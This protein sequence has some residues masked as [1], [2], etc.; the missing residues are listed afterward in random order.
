MQIRSIHKAILFFLV[1][2]IC[3]AHAAIVSRITNFT[4]GT[5]LYASDLNSEFNNIINTVNNLDNDNLSTTANISSSKISATIAGDG[6]GRDGG[7][8]ALSVTV[9]NSTLAISSDTVIVKDNGITKAKMAQ[10]TALSVIGNATN[11]TANVADIVAGT[12]GYVL[13]RSGTS[14]V[15]GQVL[16]AGIANSNV[17]TAKIADSNITTAKIADNAVTFAKIVGSNKSVSSSS[18]SF[19]T[20][21]ASPVFVTNLSVSLTTVGRPI[22]IF[23]QPDGSGS[24]AEINNGTGNFAAQVR[25]IRDGS[26]IG[27]WRMAF[28]YLAAPIMMNDLS[29]PAGPH[30]WTIE[31]STTGGVLAVSNL[32]LVAIEQP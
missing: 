11:A 9:D 2:I 31:V 7:T 22:Q 21:S 26:A 13:A 23:M 17:T 28:G 30:T 24:A 6:I 15:F 25:V 1:L 19:T 10:G 32:V 27:I 20:T 16:T 3:S 29:L 14:L 4:D 5:I 18:G 12:D 8:G